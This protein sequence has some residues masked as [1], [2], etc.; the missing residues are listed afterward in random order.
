MSHPT[1]PITH[2]SWGHME[3]TIQN[4]THQF[5]DCKIWPGGAKAWD[6]RITGTH[7]RPGIQPADIAEILD[8]D[9]EI[10]ILSRGMQLMLHTCPE[11]KAMLQSRGVVYHIEETRQAVDLF[12][13]LAQQGKRVGGI[14]HS[15]C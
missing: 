12:N 6:W 4:K 3:V 7:H 10:M 15:T 14:F 8:Q 13:K 5:K 11:T 2:I 1:G 9:I